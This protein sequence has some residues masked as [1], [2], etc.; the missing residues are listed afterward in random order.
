MAQL[1]VMYPSTKRT[2]HER[3]LHQFLPCR[4]SFFQKHWHGAA[5][6]MAHHVVNLLLCVFVPIS[7]NVVPCR[8]QHAAMEALLDGLPSNMPCSAVFPVIINQC[9]L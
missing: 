3:Q 8:R 1:L 6:R 5:L 4:C 9:S 2:A 7:A